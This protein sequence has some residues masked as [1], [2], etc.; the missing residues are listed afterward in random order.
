MWLT[1]FFLLLFPVY[2][3]AFG[4]ESALLT[5]TSHLATLAA[6]G[7]VTLAAKWRLACVDAYIPCSII[8]RSI[9]F[10]Y[11]QKRLVYL[12]AAC[13]PNYMYQVHYYFNHV[14]FI[15]DLAMIKENLKIVVFVSAPIYM[16]SASILLK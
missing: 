13:V 12:P 9:V 11:T 5:F 15:I 3:K 1:I 16:F 7:V 2:W 4:F 8:F 6:Y 14:M 10:F